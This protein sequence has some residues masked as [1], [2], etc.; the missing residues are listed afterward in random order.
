V[1]LSEGAVVFCLEP[2]DR[3]RQRGATIHA[4]IHGFGVGCDAGHVT[5]PDVNGVARTIRSALDTIDAA[6][7][8]GV[9]AH[10]TGTQVNDATEIDALRRAFAPQP[11]P[12]V[13]A[14]KSVLGHPQAAA[15]AFSL[16][17]AVQS[18]EHRRVPATA[19][20]RQVAPDLADVDI[21]HGAARSL[22]GDCLLVDAFGFGGNNCVMVV[23]DAGSASH[24]THMLDAS[25]ATAATPGA[26]R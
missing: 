10:G 15:G 5:A 1:L 14:I 13:T 12:P 3:A 19:W 18:L 21:V 24:A 6:R 11:V 17:A 22:D 26:A 4:V 2:L 9:F 7:I 16:L 25:Q 23:G 8:G 20:V